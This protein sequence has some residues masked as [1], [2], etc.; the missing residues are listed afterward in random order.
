VTPAEFWFPVGAAALYLYDSARLLW[1][2]ELV[3][4]PAR[5]GWQVLGGTEL[6]LAGRRVFLPNPLLPHRP[7]FIVCW[8][9]ADAAA[10]EGADIPAPLLRALTPIGTLNVLQVLL[11]L[12]LPAALWGL[13]TGLVA[14]AVFF[15]F[16]LLTLVA[17]G[18]AWRRRADLGLRKR[19]FWA[20][21]LDALLCAPFA[22]NLTRKLAMHHGLAGEPLRFAAR[23]FDDAM[24]ARTR[25]LVEAR[26]REEYADPDAA[27]RGA[28]ILTNVLPRLMR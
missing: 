19:D 14:L 21:A 18:L 20:L 4:Q 5:R 16:Y 25:I 10:S 3:F 1:Q 28:A 9:Q 8:S 2:N 12:A 26:V 23:H 11:L 22:P 15:L 17:L 13:G 7:Q 6:R 27:G 24:L